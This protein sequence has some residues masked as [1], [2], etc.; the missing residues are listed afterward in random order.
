M[1]EQVE[2]RVE[3]RVVEERDGQLVER[4]GGGD[5]DLP[6]AERLA[7]ARG[8]AEHLKHFAITNVRVQ[9]STVSR[10]PWEDVA[11]V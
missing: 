8:Q 11:D 9:K 2:K 7:Q 5:L 6:E 10:T 1:P 4:Y 3:Y